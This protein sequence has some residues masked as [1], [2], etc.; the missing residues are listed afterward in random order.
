MR[1]KSERLPRKAY[2][3]NK[4]LP[5][6][7]QRHHTTREGKPGFSAELRKE[8]EVLIAA[9]RAT[10]ASSTSADSA[11]GDTGA[12]GPGCTGGA[13]ADRAL[14]ARSDKTTVEHVSNTFASAPSVGSSIAVS[15]NA[16]ALSSINRVISKK[17]NSLNLSSPF[18]RSI[19]E[20]ACQSF[21]ECGARC[22]A[23]PTKCD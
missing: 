13:L 5:K 1:S 20:V 21:V 22:C 8:M 11:V 15:T 12:H 7:A 14:L 19:H 3:T 4:K 23:D 10:S 18:S 9:A 17:P 16:N 2:L 6:G